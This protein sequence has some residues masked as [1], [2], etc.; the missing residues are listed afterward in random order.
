MW[1][2]S[3]GPGPCPRSPGPGNARLKFLLQNYC[4]EWGSFNG[5]ALSGN[6]EDRY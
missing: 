6:G 5:G 4:T 3:Y 2:T 1:G